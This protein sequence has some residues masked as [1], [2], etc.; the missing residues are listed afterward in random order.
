[1]RNVV[2]LDGVEIPGATGPVVGLTALDRA[3]GHLPGW[4]VFYDPEVI[5]TGNA[6]NMARPNSI[7]TNNGTANETGAFPVSDQVAFD[8][9][10]AR[11]VRPNIAHPNNEWTAFAV[12]RLSSSSI[13]QHLGGTATPPGSGRSPDYGFIP[14]GNTAVIWDR[15]VNVRLC[16]YTPA[17]S[18]A[19]RTALVMFTFS[20]RDGMRIFENGNQVAHSP[21]A[22][23]VFTAGFNAGEWRH[24]NGMRGLIGNFGLLSVDLG[25]SENLGFRRRLSDYMLAKYAITP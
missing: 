12:V 10:G 21:G 24:W 6:R 5:V 16:E 13:A 8:L 14:N 15:G 2:E 23:S 18:F 22:N 25:W 7:T 17:T 4:V 19:G 11:Q 9:P 1:M 3:I 20:T